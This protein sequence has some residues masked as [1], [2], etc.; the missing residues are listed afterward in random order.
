LVTCGIC[1]RKILIQVREHTHTIDIFTSKKHI[2]EKHN[3]HQTA[4]KTNTF[5]HTVGGR[6]PPAPVDW[7]FI[8]LFIGVQPSKV[9]QD[10]PSTVGIDP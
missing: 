9:V 8:P 6:N 3:R 4:T 1:P 2:R 5:I 10:L 7:W